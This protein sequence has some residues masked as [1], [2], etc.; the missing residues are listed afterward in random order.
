M[1]KIHVITLRLKC[2]QVF[3]INNDKRV[4][5]A[6]IPSTYLWYTQKPAMLANYPYINVSMYLAQQLKN[7]HSNIQTASIATIH[8]TIYFMAFI[9][10]AVR[11]LM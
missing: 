5:Y 4:L 1:N 9:N 3:D 10:I 8:T 2:L 11:I 7:T 6:H